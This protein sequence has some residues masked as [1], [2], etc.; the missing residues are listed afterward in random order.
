MTQQPYYAPPP[1][2]PGYP[3]APPAQPQYPPQQPVQYGQPA[4]PQPYPQQQAPAQPLAQG[5]LDDFYNQ[6]SSGGGAGLKFEQLGTR[7]IGIVTRPIG[8]GDIQQQTNTQ[9]VPQTFK[10]GRPKWVMKVPL[11]L[12]PTADRPDGLAQWYVK[13]QARDELVRA[14]AEAHAPEGPPEAGA[15]LDITFTATRQ[16][17]VGMNPAKVFQVR[18]QRP[19]GAQP[20]SQPV[21]PAAPVVQQA[22]APVA[23]SP[24]TGQQVTVEQL[25]Q[26]PAPQQL[27]PQYAP[28]PANYA[29]A[30]AQT[31]APV[32]FQQPLPPQQMQPQQAI[33]QVAPVA[34]QVGGFNAEQM[35]LLQKLTNAQQ[36]PQ[37]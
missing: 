7:Y 2:Y 3:P 35:E 21:A 33:Q 30:P 17:G 25:V 11:Q 28:P 32:P 34:P 5:T 20:V 14:M 27:A 12:Q 13:G 16:S 23:P 6:P 36:A 37:Q 9:G 31:T 26:Q 19:Q 4:Y 15:V 22:P 10:D 29:P 18:Y 8:S 1:Q 24:A